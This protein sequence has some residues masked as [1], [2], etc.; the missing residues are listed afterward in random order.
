MSHR[1]ALPIASLLALSAGLFAC[2]SSASSDLRTTVVKPSLPVYET[3]VDPILT[4]RCGTLDCHG[5]PGRPFR[6]YGVAGLRIF[7]RATTDEQARPVSGATLP[8]EA[9]K[10]Q[11]K[12]ERE[13]NYQ[14]IIGLEPEELS[15]VV[16]RGGTTPETLLLFRKGGGLESHKGG[17]GGIGGVIR[18]CII[19][20]LGTRSDTPDLTPAQ[21]EKCA[22]AQ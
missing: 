6:L 20:W 17:A 22:A 18:E 7:E 9:E 2:A 13:R 16:L 12:K 21:Q 8:A 1:V 15:R 5:Q 3:Y 14:A 4:R 11:A 19:A 10:A